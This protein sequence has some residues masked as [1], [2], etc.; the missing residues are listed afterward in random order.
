V[1]EVGSQPLPSLLAEMAAGFGRGMTVA[2][3]TPSADPAW[4]EGIVDLIRRGLTP[5]AVVL[6][7]RS[8]GAGHDSAAL[9]VNWPNSALRAI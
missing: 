1:A 8:F 6:D 3:V 7:S 4:I 2:V 9:M 5:S